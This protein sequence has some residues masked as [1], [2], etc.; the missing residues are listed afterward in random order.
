MRTLLMLFCSGTDTAVLG[1][2]SS[3]FTLVLRLYLSDKKKKK[4]KILSNIQQCIRYL[5]EHGIWCLSDTKL[6]APTLQ[7]GG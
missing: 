6:F 7:P 5:L 4:W 3:P 2:F 1:V